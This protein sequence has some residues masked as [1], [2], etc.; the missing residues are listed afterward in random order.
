MPP[1]RQIRAARECL[2]PRATWDRYQFK[3]PPIDH[4][5]YVSPQDIVWHTN[6]HSDSEPE[7]RNRNFDMQRDKGRVLDGNWDVKAHRFSELK[8]YQAIKLRI[9]MEIDWVDTEFFSESLRDIE[10]GIALW[11]CRSRQDL[12]ARCESVDL[13]ISDMR[14]NGY[15][16]GYQSL[17]PNEDMGRLAKHPR[18]SEEITVNIGRE[19]DFFF[20]DG[21]HRLAIAKSLG[22]E[23]IPVKV[24][25]RH[26]LWC[27]KLIQ[28]STENDANAD[29]PDLAYKRDVEPKHV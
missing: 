10:A 25:V 1:I 18:Y 7:L 19:G 14:N 27:E 5:F 6:L 11:G 2:R 8:V 28:A 24:L 29:H 20:Q 13:I 21:R 17:L 15:R 12:I 16:A 3:L 23:T 4:I 9:E 22:I 26:R